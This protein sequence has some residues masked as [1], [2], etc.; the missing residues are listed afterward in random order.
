MGQIFQGLLYLVLPFGIVGFLIWILELSPR[1]R[2]MIE[3]VLIIVDPGLR[4]GTAD[5]VIQNVA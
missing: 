1:R 4:F 3:A 5:L 2:R